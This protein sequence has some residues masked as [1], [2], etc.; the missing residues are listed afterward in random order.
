[1]NKIIRLMVMPCKPEL[2]RKW[3]GVFEVKLG[4]TII[5]RSRQPFVDGARALL[6]M[7]YDPEMVL[8]MRHATT[9]TDALKAKLRVAAKLAVD[10]SGPHLRRWKAMPP[11]EGYGYSDEN[12]SEAAE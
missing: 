3:A 9:G 12:G 2:H 1:M 8:V 10:T 4:E 5:C 6:A 11:R 7:G